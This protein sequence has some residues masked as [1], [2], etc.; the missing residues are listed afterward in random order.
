MNLLGRSQTALS[1]QLQVQQH[2][3]QGQDAELLFLIGSVGSCKLT[4]CLHCL[5]KRRLLKLPII[6]H[7]PPNELKN[8]KYYFENNANADR[9][10]KK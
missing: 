1:V 3:L 2:P 9:P 5:Q 4:L 8:K 6:G 10:P 7:L